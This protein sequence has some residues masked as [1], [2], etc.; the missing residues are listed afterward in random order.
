MRSA[1]VLAGGGST[2]MRSD[3]GLK[4]LAGVP[5]VVHTLGRLQDTVDEIVIVLGSEEQREAYAGVLKDADMVVDLYDIGTPLVGAI[6]G[7]EAVKGDY[8]LVAACDMPFISPEAV[9]LLFREAEGH[10]GAVFQWPNG[11]IEPFLAVYKVGSALPVAQE[12]IGEG[13]LRVRMILRRLG[14]VVMIPMDSLRVL[15][16]DLLSLHDA[17]TEESLLEAEKILK[18]EKK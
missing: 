16:P 2:R 10:D 18:K 3:K 8:A 7:F 6:T 13:N 17:D 15:D 4:T 12:L 14:D 9:D 11:W 5:L 1:I